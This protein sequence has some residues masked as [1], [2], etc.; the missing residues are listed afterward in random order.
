MDH[1]CGINRKRFKD[2]L[3]EGQDTIRPTYPPLRDA[4]EWMIA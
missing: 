2:G 3:S 4:G 1:V